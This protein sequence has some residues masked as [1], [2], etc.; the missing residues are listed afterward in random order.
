MMGPE[1]SSRVMLRDNKIYQTM[2]ELS[3]D[4]ILTLEPPSWG[5]T[6][7]NIADYKV[8]SGVRE[9]GFTFKTPPADLPTVS[10]GWATVC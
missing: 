3:R 7:C 1:T 5:I 8:I 2:F 4:A 6:A 9:R 10:T